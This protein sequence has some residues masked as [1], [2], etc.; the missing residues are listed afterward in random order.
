MQSVCS[1]VVNNADTTHGTV[2][3]E[4]VKENHFLILESA[5][6]K[7]LGT[8][9]LPNDTLYQLE[10]FNGKG[11]FMAILTSPQ[12]AKYFALPGSSLAVQGIQVTL[13]GEAITS[14]PSKA[15]T[16]FSYDTAKPQQ[17]TTQATILGAGLATRFERISGDSTQYSK[18]AVPLVGTQSVIELIANTLARYGFSH[19]IVNTY[20]KP[21]SLKASL[22]Q[23][24]IKKI[25]YIDEQ[26]PSGT[27]GGLQKML[28]GS[29]FQGILN[30][31]EPLLVVQGDSVTDVDFAALMEQHIQRD[32]LVTLGCQLI[33]EKDV[34]KFGIIVTDQSGDDGQSGRITGFQEKPRPEEAKSRLGNTGFYIFSPKAYP[35]VESAYQALLTHAQDNARKTGG[36]IPD[37][38]LFDFAKDLFPKI[39]EATQN[40]PELGAFWAQSVKGYWSD[41]GNPAQYIE[42]VHDIYA[43][44]V[45]VPLPPDVTRYYDGGVI[46]WEGAKAV[47][48]K[49][50][51][52]LKGNL[53]VALPFAG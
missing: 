43:G 11:G 20:F 28:S 42:S 24:S 47:A 34:D 6:K 31:N 29:G 32:A 41:I 49:E 5:S 19:L 53:V 37:A 18:P 7:E 12:G 35:L 46:Y 33:D 14:N 9:Y 2:A 40:N 26:E 15:Q 23:S 51:A 10:L 27:A 21:D 45:N 44:K 52:V 48:E 3:L 1:I 4:T 13:H 30:Q 8:V 36:P 16:Q 17:H 25:D 22:A 38:V 39:L 50:S